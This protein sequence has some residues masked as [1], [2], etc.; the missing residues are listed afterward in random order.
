MPGQLP[1]PPPEGA[2]EGAVVE[3]VVVAEGVVVVLGT[4]V[5]PSVAVEGVVAV[6]AAGVAVAV[7]PELAA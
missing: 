5:P 3:G 7:L 4:T 6:A 2:G 1:E